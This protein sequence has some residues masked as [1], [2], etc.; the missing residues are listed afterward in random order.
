MRKAELLK[1]R[2]HAE[3]AGDAGTLRRLDSE[4]EDLESQAE[5]IDRRR[6]LGFK[7]ITSINQRNR[8]L[9]VQQAEEAI[10][11]E[12]EAAQLSN[13]IDP[14][15]RVHSQPVIVTKKYLEE[16]RHKRVDH[17]FG[18]RRYGSIFLIHQFEVFY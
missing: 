13:E 12:S 4:L 7:S 16:L 6:T 2:E 15:T 1:Q 8:V 11:Q 17:S 18:V 10:R 14:F 9:S 3:V 5:R